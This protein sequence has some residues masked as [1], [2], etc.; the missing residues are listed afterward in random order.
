MQAINRYF[1][2]NATLLLR[3]RGGA[4]QWVD[5]EGRMTP[6][7]LAAYERRRPEKQGI[8]TYEQDGEPVLPP[9]YER[10]LRDNPAA[11]AWFDAAT[12]SYRRIAVRWVLTAQRGHSACQPQAWQSISGA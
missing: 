2:S 4:S 8:Y 1:I 11:A 5:L 3:N 10:R 7:G 6:A 12:P 9:E